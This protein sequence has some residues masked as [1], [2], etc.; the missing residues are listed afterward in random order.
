[1]KIDLSYKEYRIKSLI[2]LQINIIKHTTFS[3][4]LKK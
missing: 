2:I 3:K 1:M 4:R